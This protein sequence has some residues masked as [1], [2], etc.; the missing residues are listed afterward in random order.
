MNQTTFHIRAPQPGA[1]SLQRAVLVYNDRGGRA[2]LATVHDI[3]DVEGEAVIGPGRAMSACAARK[4]AADLC[5]HASS[6]GFLPETVLFLHGNLMLWWVPPAHC[7]VA[8]RTPEHAAQMGGAERGET[9]PH[10]GLVFAA[11]PNLWRVWA[12]KGK[13]RPTLSSA[14]YQAP[15]FN[16]NGQGGICRGSVKVP[17]G[18]TVERIDAW[19]EAFFQSFFTHPNVSGK[20]VRYRGGAYGFWRDMLDGKH[21]RFPER[22]LVDVGTT[23]GAL[24]G[25]KEKA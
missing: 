20:L 6:S 17:D 12:V 3:E 18:T 9:V 24:L 25:A 2:A 5:G 13:T 10:P 22:V 16:V 14:L 19:N 8:F 7:H 23:L 1:V 15:Y 21:R 4:L 11:S